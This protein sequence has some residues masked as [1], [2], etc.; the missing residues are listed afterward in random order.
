MKYSFMKHGLFAIVGILAFVVINGCAGSKN[1]VVSLDLTGSEKG[2]INL[3]P[4]NSE[5]TRKY[6][7]DIKM[8]SEI[9]PIKGSINKAIMEDI[10]EKSGRYTYTFDESDLEH[11]RT[12]IVR[13]LATTDY[14][15]EVNDISTI[16]SDLSN[17]GIRIY[18]E[19]KSMGVSQ[20]LA[21]ICEINAH[22]KI[23]DS[24]EKTITEKDINVREKGIITLMAA[25]NKA[26]K[27]FVL[28]IGQLLNN[29]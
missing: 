23:C 22:A 2:A 5:F 21:F 24:A 12:S 19:F 1:Q 11:L 3:M 10:A 13:S 27:K 4:F 6:Y 25:K 14:Y 20:N 7:S 17:H 26:I 8:R 18:I 16:G 9:T 15:K 29:A 28:E